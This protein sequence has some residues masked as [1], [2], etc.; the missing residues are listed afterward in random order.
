MIQFDEYF[1]ELKPPSRDVCFQE[2]GR[3]EDW[4]FVFLLKFDV[5]FCQMVA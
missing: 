4:E 5:T 1:R 3:I 2:T